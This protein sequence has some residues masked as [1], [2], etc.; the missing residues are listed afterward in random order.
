VPTA[1]AWTPEG[2]VVVAGYFAGTLDPAGAALPGAGG[3]DVWVAR[4]A[5]ADG[6]VM[7]IHRGGGPGPDS[8]HAV[9]AGQDG[10]VVV[11]GAF[12]RWA[13]FSATTL[14]SEDSTADP[15]VAA[16]GPDGFGAAWS[17]DAQ[18]PGIAR[19][20]VTGPGSRLA[21][22][23]TF[24]GSLQVGRRHES[25]AAGSG[26]VALVH[27]GGDVEWA[28]MTPGSSAE[29][30]AAGGDGFLVAGASGAGGY[31]AAISA[32][33]QP[34]WSAA[35]GQAVPA[36]IA[37]AAKRVLVGGSASG[38]LTVGGFSAAVAGESDGFVARLPAP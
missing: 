36:A 19:A 35:I 13:D 15:F 6:R 25:A 17:L 4:L 18:G 16:V 9:A 2:D 30:I 12:Q 22:A 11:A 1:L 27:G 26:L 20:V 7:W 21:L 37:A 5:G 10:S 14:R 23:I 31:V 3:L 34:T 24:S 32:A 33:G 8:A 38:R 28:R 29:A